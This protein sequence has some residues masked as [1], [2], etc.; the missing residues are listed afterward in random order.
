MVTPDYYELLQVS[1]NADAEIIQ[2]AYRRLARKWH[3]DVNPGDPFAYERM[4]LLNEAYETLSDPRKRQE[5]DTRRSAT[6]ASGEAKAEAPRAKTREQE[7]PA[8]TVPRPTGA[9]STA[10]DEEPRVTGKDSQDNPW[11]GIGAAFGAVVA[12]L[13]LVYG[14]PKQIGGMFTII[15]LTAFFGLKEWLD[16]RE[17]KSHSARQEAEKPNAHQDQ[18]SHR[19]ES[20]PS[21]PSEP[22]RPKPRTTDDHRTDSRAQGSLPRWLLQGPPLSLL[23]L[24]VIA[25]VTIMVV[26]ASYQPKASPPKAEVPPPPKAEALPERAS[27]SLASGQDWLRKKDYTRAL[28]DYEE[29][30][31]L[32]PNSNLACYR[33]AWLLATCP[34]SEIRDGKRA[35]QL[36]TRACNLSGWKDGIDLDVLAAAY[37]EAGDFDNAILYLKK[38][39]ENPHPLLE[40]DYG[41]AFR[42][43]LALYEQRKPFRLNP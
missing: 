20:A 2:V 43:R 12:L 21:A 19:K 17:K 37:A 38:A 39:L 1:P 6:V 31:R 30:I 33:C 34:D 28:R 15:F 42:Q 32:D 26:A 9:D 13:T 24:A 11:L 36:A 22:R 40:A 7:Q 35:I 3:P 16:G 25:S 5:Y 27:A 4:K 14:T 8:P 41:D 18:R 29:A 10:R 23:V